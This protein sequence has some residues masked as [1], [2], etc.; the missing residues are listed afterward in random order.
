MNILRGQ[1]NVIEFPLTLGREFCGVLLQKGMNITKCGLALGQ[2][3]WGVVPLNKAHGSHAEYV[4][5]PEHCVK[6][7]HILNS[8]ILLLMKCFLS[9]NY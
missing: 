3:V 1:T 5:V 7:F 9:K 8:L 4:V 2:R 6:S